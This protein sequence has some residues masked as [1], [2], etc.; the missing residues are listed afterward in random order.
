[1]IPAITILI[2]AWTISGICSANYL[3]TGGYIGN[4]VNDL[5]AKNAAF[6]IFI[7]PVITFV[8]AGFLAFATGTSWGTMAL[9]IPIGVAICKTPATAHML[10]PILGSILAGAVYGDHISPISD[11]TILSSTG[12]QCNHLDHVS[13]QMIYA[14]LVAGCS[15]IGYILMGMINQPWIPLLVSLALMLVSIWYLNKR[16]QRKDAKE[17][18]TA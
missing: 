5:I 4:L 12:A 13:T 10:M 3:N 2:L 16:Q 1:M 18:T 6:P 7:I 9:F 11:T 14:S 15:A 8:I 17:A